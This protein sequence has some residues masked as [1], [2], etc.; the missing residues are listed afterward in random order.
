MPVLPA[1][2]LICLEDF[3][4]LHA[5]ALKSTV[6]CCFVRGLE[7]TWSTCILQTTLQLEA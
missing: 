2:K 7:E 6:Q 4:Y 1:S 3:S 5:P